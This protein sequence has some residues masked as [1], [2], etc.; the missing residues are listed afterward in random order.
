MYL[1]WY[2]RLYVSQILLYLA[3]N[4]KTAFVFFTSGPS[5]GRELI[6]QT[7]HS[8]LL[9]RSNWYSPHPIPHWPMYLGASPQWT[10]RQ[11]GA[12]RDRDREW[13]V[14]FSSG[15]VSIQPLTLSLFFLIKK[16]K[17]NSFLD[18]KFSK[19]CLAFFSY[20]D[21]HVWCYFMLFIECFG[22]NINF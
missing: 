2:N 6:D 1:A 16:M 5:C 22:E 7:K 12:D 15:T 14:A 11:K 20:K 4:L 18:S 13:K 17:R 19:F 10:F 9:G 3:L 8:F 21:S